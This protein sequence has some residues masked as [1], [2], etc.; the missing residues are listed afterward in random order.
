MSQNKKD[1]E[2]H[3]DSE[4]SCKNCQL[5]LEMAE[6][7]VSSSM[8]QALYQLKYFENLC[9]ANRDAL[10]L[11]YCSETSTKKLSFILRT[12]DELEKAYPTAK[13]QEIFY[14]NTKYLRPQMPFFFP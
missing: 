3:Y 4:K 11:E 6:N 8:K 13:G 1:K 10:G 14:Y 5:S 9:T 7:F 12:L 2:G